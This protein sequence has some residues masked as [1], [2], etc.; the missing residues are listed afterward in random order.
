MTEEHSHADPA[1]RS[2]S[3][4]SPES[5][6]DAAN[7]LL[8]A[9]GLP[10][11]AEISAEHVEPA[12]SNVLTAQREALVRLESVPAPDAGWLRALECIHDDLHRVWSPVS[13]LNAVASS[14]ALREAFNRCLPLITEFN[15]ELGQNEALF[16][17][18]ERLREELPSGRPVETELVSQT[19]RDFRLAGVAL[20]TADKERFRNVKQAL[21]AREAEF[22]QNLM[23]VSD[24]FEHHETR[25]EALAGLPGVVLERAREAAAK[26]G[27]EGWL[28][29]L[30][31]PTYLAVMSNAQ[32]AELRERFYQAWVT[33]ASDQGPLAGRWDNGPLIAEILALRH[34][35]A[36]LLGFSHY[37]ELSLATKMAESP[38]AVLA[39][40]H[41]LAE[42]SRPLAERDLAE[43]EACACRKLDAWDV[44]YFSEQLRRR[45]FALDQEQLRAYFP[46]PKVLEGLFGLAERL[47]GLLITERPA[48]GLWHPSV[49]YY[50]IERRGGAHVGGLFIDLFARPNKRGG[51]WMDDCLDRARLPDRRQDP[52]AHLVCNFNPPSGGAPSL[53]THGDVVTLFHEFGHTL[54]HLLTRVDYPSLAG[55]NGVAWDAVELPSQFFE[56]YAWLPEVLRAISGHHESGE[57]LPDDK[58]EVL[59]RSR[60]FLAGLSMLRQLEFSLFDF[61]LHS[62]PEPASLERTY[63]IL[64]EVRREVAIIEP[65]RYNRFPHG[66]AHVF[67]GGYAAGYY[68]Y[69]WAE[70][71]AADAFAAFEE[72]GPFDAGTA[73]SFEQ[74][75]LAVGG[76]RPALDA[77][78]AFRGRPPELGP[79]LAQAGISAPS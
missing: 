13:H 50:D 29:P 45:R 26:N 75:V 7:P 15:T 23:D 53:L 72:S 67:G 61:R 28:L 38:E 65:P 8:E 27:L 52:V 43:L 40:L 10:R 71:L 79:L 37:A 47:F 60:K 9:N 77:F 20:P 1:A 68:S 76:S 25:A 33:R 5:G 35:S 70:V 19:L 6:R 51:A 57:A 12:V 39:F 36:R 59:N 32:S 42:R 14:P 49:R 30:D 31:M 46:L 69:K 11:F 58:I 22:E 74:A 41:D 66:F 55:I 34:E 48:A 2:R 73:R 16:G 17:Q 44:A 21:A 54:H 62:E 64:E 56:N 24:A 78:V 4:E 18:F 3:L 63:R